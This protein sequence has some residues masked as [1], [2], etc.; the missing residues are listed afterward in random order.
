MGNITLESLC[1]L[2]KSNRS[3]RRFNESKAI[4]DSTLQQLVGLTRYC[5]SARN[6]QPLRYR[7]V[8]SQKERDAIFP[9]LK[10][11]GYLSDWEGPAPSERPSAYLIQCLDVSLTTNCL[12]DDG[13]QLEAITL[14]A[15]ALGIHGCII[16]AFNVPEIIAALHLPEQYKPLYVL[17]LG[18]PAEKV[19]VTD[20]DGS[21]DA[22]IRYYRTAD[23]THI[24]PKR[25]VSELI[26]K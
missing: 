10:W 6:L 22:D 5:A 26:I 25:P 17:A 21:H 19:V 14:G 3:Y 24:V 4:T 7:I 13:L 20:T 11:A 8:S 9:A 16:K 1:E 2:L 23:S 15:S 12:C 18:Y